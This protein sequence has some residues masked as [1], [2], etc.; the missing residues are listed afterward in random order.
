MVAENQAI[1]NNNCD[2]VT[3]EVDLTIK[4]LKML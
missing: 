4:S 2:Y 1:C 3:I